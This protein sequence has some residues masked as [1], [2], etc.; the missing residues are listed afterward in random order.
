MTYPLILL[1][2]DLS[3]HQDLIYDCPHKWAHLALG[4]FDLWPSLY[5][6]LME[7]G[8][9]SFVFPFGLKGTHIPQLC[10]LVLRR[11]TP[12][13]PVARALLPL[14]TD[15]EGLFQQPDILS[16]CGSLRYHTEALGPTLFPPYDK[17]IFFHSLY[18]QPHPV[19]ILLPGPWCQ[20]LKTNRVSWYAPSLS[21]TP[22][23]HK[24]TGRNV[25]FD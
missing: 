2:T 11:N 10:S 24:F 9:H 13:T 25:Y 22:S 14:A 21:F 8:P 4:Y 18:K 16:F 19:T 15:E 23:A 20:S 12:P 7:T 3:K 1:L 6:R 5:K 17:I